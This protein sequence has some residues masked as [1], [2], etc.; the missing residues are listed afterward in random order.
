MEPQILGRRLAAAALRAPRGPVRLRMMGAR[1]P[2]GGPNTS[3]VHAAGGN[4]AQREQQQQQRGLS[5][6]T[7]RFFRQPSAPP[8]TA[9]ATAAAAAA[10][11]AA[12]AASRFAPRPSRLPLQQGQRQQQ[13]L[14]LSRD[15]PLSL[16]EALYLSKEAGC[17]TVKELQKIILTSPSF[18]SDSSPFLLE[19]VF[20]S[21]GSDDPS[22]L[23]EEDEDEVETPAAAAAGV[24]SREAAE[25]SAVEAAAAADNLLRAHIHNSFDPEKRKA[26]SSKR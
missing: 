5:S 16:S 11:A 15:T 26:G 21:A 22:E 8:P 24:G 3:C 4:L 19:N 18:S 17:F 7:S 9:A 1:C 13:E 6:S 23:G 20:A 2:Q 12:P 25:A 10:A 14:P